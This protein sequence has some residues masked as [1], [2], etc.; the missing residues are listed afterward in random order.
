MLDSRPPIPTLRS[1]PKLSSFL[2]FSLICTRLSASPV[3]QVVIEADSYGGGKEAIVI[4]LE[5]RDERR[6]SR[7]GG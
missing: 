1:V 7:T 5:A 6:A 4:N 2:R 3:G